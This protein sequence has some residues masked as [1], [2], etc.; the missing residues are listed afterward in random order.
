MNFLKKLS[1]SSI[2]N[3]SSIISMTII[4]KILAL[5]SGPTGI[6][7]FALFREY[8]KLFS[9]AL[10]FKSGDAVVQ[11]LRENH[12]SVL[13]K[14]SSIVTFLLIYK[15]I[16]ILLTGAIC[17]V[18][19]KQILD[20]LQIENIYYFGA[21]IVIGLIGAV[22]LFNV[23][24]LNTEMKLLQMSISE[25][26]G[27]FLALGYTFYLLI[28]S[29][30][31]SE[32]QILFI[33]TI[34][35]LS[36]FLINLYQ[37]LKYKLYEGVMITTNRIKANTNHF[38]RISGVSV[39]IVV[40][41]IV[42]NLIVKLRILDYHGSDQLG[43]FEASWTIASVYMLV[44]LTGLNRF[45]LPEFTSS[46]SLNTLF[47]SYLSWAFAILIPIL[48][49][50]VLFGDVI[51]SI[52]YNKEFRISSALIQKMAFGDIFKIYSWML[53]LAFLAK[54]R[55]REYA[56]TSFIFNFVLIISVY[57]ANKDL[58]N[59][60]GIYYIGCHLIYFGVNVILAWKY[61][62]LIPSYKSLIEL[63]VGL[64]ILGCGVLLTNIYMK[65]IFLL[66]IAGLSI[67]I[68]TKKLNVEKANN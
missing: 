22:N 18:Y 27:Y 57:N 40:A 34:I 61:L 7:I 41:G 11:Q 65:L 5:S 3:M 24:L 68:I 50:F 26:I 14:K 8:I 25:S 48:L 12:E 10:S 55:V 29:K 20:L 60:I 54:R 33:F 38:L 67:F 23:A 4:S 31:I 52:L 49:I 13:E 9:Q 15:S 19:H 28:Y 32:K 1:L 42:T 59:E 6:A 37:I 53:T 58:L 30:P 16:F 43:L 51:L 63:L 46:N 64:I 35:Y 2:G 45:V 21:I 17:F 36:W 39:A 62:N 56:I 66:S 47:S 44:V